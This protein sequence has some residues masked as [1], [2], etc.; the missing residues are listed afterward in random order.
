MPGSDTR[1][2]AD[3]LATY[4]TFAQC[5]HDDLVALAKAG[6][7]FAVPAG[8]SFV[9]EGIPSDA[10][11]VIMEGSAKVYQDRKVIATLG[12]GDVVGE[13]TLLAGGQRRATVSS[14]SAVRGLRIENDVLTDLLAKRP[15]LRAAL[16]A[17]YQ[18]HSG[19]ARAE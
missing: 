9:Q 14:V 12:E 5:S 17:V 18:A 15:Q 11:Y 19:E 1:E 4:P 6:S 8:W 10:C 3:K 16:D 7:R 13:M 2:I